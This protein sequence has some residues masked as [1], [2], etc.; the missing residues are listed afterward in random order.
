MA[1]KKESGAK[2][3]DSQKSRRYLAAKEVE[4]SGTAQPKT[5]TA[6]KSTDERPPITPEI[7]IMDLVHNYPEAVPVLIEAGLHCIGCQ[8]SVFDTLEGGCRLHGFDDET[9]EKLIKEMNERVKKFN[10]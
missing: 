2:K 6:G 5:Q 10:K 4:N 8:L 3:A 9:I 1:E 7:N